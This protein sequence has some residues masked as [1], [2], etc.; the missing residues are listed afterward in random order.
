MPL[1]LA[2]SILLFS[3]SPFAFSKNLSESQI[4][5]AY[6]YNTLKFAV[7]TDDKPINV[8]L[9]GS[10]NVSDILEKTLPERKIKQKKITVTLIK[11]SYLVNTDKTSLLTNIDAVYVSGKFNRS[12]VVKLL[13]ILSQHKILTISTHQGFAGLGGMIEIS[14]RDDASKHF[15]FLVNITSIKQQNMVL[16]S[17]FLRLTKQV[18]TQL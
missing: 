15:D 1:K 2:L 5:A 14:R 8:L 10:D 12:L 6:F 13:K 7:W 3:C 16:Q 17:Q 18:D 4:Q 9:I 11:K